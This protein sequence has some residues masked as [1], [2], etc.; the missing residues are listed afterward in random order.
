MG[1]LKLKTKISLEDYLKGEKITLAGNEFV[2]GEVFAMAEMSNNRSRICINLTTALSIHLRDSN[3][4]LFAGETKVR[5]TRNAYYYPDVLVSCEDDS[6]NPHFRNAPNQNRT[7]P[8][9]SERWL[10]NLLF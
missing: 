10:D 8:P 2:E 9:T 3:C 6:E 4:E 1:L 7:S 5:V